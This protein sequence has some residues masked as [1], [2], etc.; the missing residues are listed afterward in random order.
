[1]ITVGR[2]GM[3]NS[4]GSRE[5]HGAPALRRLDPLAGDSLPPLPPRLLAK[6]ATPTSCHLGQL[7]G[8]IKSEICLEIDFLRQKLFTLDG[9]TSIYPD[10]SNFFRISLVPLLPFSLK[11]LRW[12]SEHLSYDKR[13][14]GGD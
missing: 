8:E 4:C 5:H 2:E 1:M 9:A 11:I 3:L 7:V 14:Y 6:R 13:S 12:L 10:T